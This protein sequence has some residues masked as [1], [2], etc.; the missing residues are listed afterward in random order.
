[1]RELDFKG[2]TIVVDIG[3]THAKISLWSKTGKLIGR[4]VRANNTRPVSTHSYRTLDVHG[5]DAWLLE[6]MREF[7][8]H[9]HVAR[10]VAVGHGAAAA[11]LHEGKL[12]ADPMDYEVEVSEDDRIEY[13]AQREPFEITGSPALPLGLNLGI[14]FHLLERELGPFPDNLAIVPWAQYWAW[15]FC[16]VASSEVTSL[17]CHSDLWRPGSNDFSRLATR[18]GWAARMAPLRRAA[19]ALGPVTPELAAATGLNEDCEVLCGLHDSNAALLAARA[20]PAS[21]NCETTVL[22][23]GT[24]FVAMRSLAD[25]S[26]FD[27][28]A[29]DPSRDCLVNVDA[30]ARPVPSA[31]FMG[32]REAELAGGP[33]S[34]RLT[35]SCEPEELIDRVP[36]LLDQGCIAIPGFVAG[37][38]PFPNAAGAWLNR[39]R[40]P[41]SL[42]AATSLYLALVADTALTLIGSRN[43]LLIEGRF[44]G[45]TVFVK[46]LAALRKDQRVYVS[47]AEH[48]VAL[49]ALRLIDPDLSSVSKTEPVEPLALELDG[50]A[51]SWREQARRAQAVAESDRPR[52]AL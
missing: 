17:G 7:A 34:F 36:D 19:D 22:S 51:A 39:P 6:S 35:D 9:G 23:T 11:L 27:I 45:D 24:W 13:D 49:G 52:K 43:R 38:G 21:A 48:D 47:N 1:M 44:A 46:A 31:R 37:V 50:F 26:A 3:K 12:Y 16:G 2:R 32:G 10:I 25:D 28:G 30:F 8:G 14:Q 20:E 4:K 5:I 42:R 18:R 15:R 29:L 40:D 33:D 41:T